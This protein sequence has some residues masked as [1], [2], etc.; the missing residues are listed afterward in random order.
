MKGRKYLF[1]LAIAVFAMPGVCSPQNLQFL[2]GGTSS[3]FV[4]LGQAAATLIGPGACIWTSVG[5][6]FYAYDQRTANGPAFC[7][8][9]LGSLGQGHH[10]YRLFESFF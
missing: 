5:G 2:G 10:G 4:E 1:V 7:R 3:L 8:T 9:G 6:E